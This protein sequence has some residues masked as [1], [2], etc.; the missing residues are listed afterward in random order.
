MKRIGIGLVVILLVVLV[1]ARS[2]QALDW[3]EVDAGMIFLVNTDEDSAPSPIL[4]TLG[5]S[6][7]IPLFDDEDP[8]YWEASLLFFSLFYQHSLSQDGGDLYRP[9]ELEKADTLW[10][11]GVIIDTRLGYAFTLSEKVRLGGAVGLAGVLRLP[12]I[13]IEQGGQ[14]QGA[15]WS[16]FLT[17]SVYPELEISCFWRA[18]PGLG[19]SFAVRSLFPLFHIW[20]GEGTSFF[21]QMIIMG[22][23]GF[24][25]FL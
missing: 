5:V 21:D 1:P 6:I 4:N 13:A 17:R 25:I 10:T 23:I 11:L 19:F 8:F 14:Y 22:N 15:A 20:D 16:Y 12:L 2:L 18:F 24:R 3:I 7:P 9:A